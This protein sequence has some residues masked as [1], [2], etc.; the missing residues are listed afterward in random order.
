MKA[1]AWLRSLP[2]C[3]YTPSRSAAW[4]L[5]GAAL[6]VW[7]IDIAVTRYG[8]RHWQ[9]LTYIE[10]GI[11]LQTQARPYWVGLAR[12]GLALGT[13]ALLIAFS[14]AR[15]RDLGLTLGKPKVTLL[16]IGFPA[17]VMIGITIIVLLVV[18][19]L[20]RATAWPIP[21]DWLRPSFIFTQDVT[22]RVVWEMCVIAPVVEEIL[23]RG[24]PLLALERVCGRCWAVGLT[25]LI[26]MLLHLIY[27]HPIVS[28][29]WYFLYAGAL[30][31]WIFLK[32]RSL[33]TTVVL[34]AL[35]NLAVP[36]AL[37]LVL[38]YQGDVVVRLLD[39][40]RE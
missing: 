15:P 20:V 33:L 13:V 1:F 23:Y 36:V 5:L 8:E 2:K 16:W 32:S 24:I 27:G 25:G 35:W 34:H 18:C 10:N 38:L 30:F 6:L 22:W 21:P 37:D 7:P 17:A 11:R 12:L 40:G 9:T 4:W 19:L 26:W 29:P 3:D 39:Q 31:A 14:P 28:A